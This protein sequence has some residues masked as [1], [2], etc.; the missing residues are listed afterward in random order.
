[1]LAS[2]LFVG[3]ARGISV[4][5]SEGRVIDTIV[6][7]LS[8]PLDDVPRFAAAALMV[9]IQALIHVPVMSNSGQAV[10]TMPIMAPLADVL[11]FSRQAVVFA[12]Q[13]GGAMM[14]MITPTN[15]A[16]LA[17]LLAAD[18]PYTRWLRFAVPGAL[19]VSV[20]GFA[21]IALLVR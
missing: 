17:M 14:D 2:A 11:G 4:V 1:M 8:L 6:H 10:L 18:V 5:F 16:L 20:V 3:I 7:G 15:G 13:T 19:L 12:Y 21:A 9:P